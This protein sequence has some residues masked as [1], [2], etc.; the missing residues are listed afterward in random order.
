MRSKLKAVG[1]S[2]HFHKLSS[3]RRVEQARFG[4]H[5]QC[6]TLSETVA[7]SIR[8]SIGLSES[9]LWRAKLKKWPHWPCWWDGK[10]R[11]GRSRK[12]FYKPYPI[13]PS[14]FTTLLF[15]AFCPFLTFHHFVFDCVFCCE[16]NTIRVHLML[17]EW[18]DCCCCFCPPIFHLLYVSPVGFMSE[19]IQFPPS[20]PALPILS[21]PAWVSLSFPSAFV[22]TFEGKYQWWKFVNTNT[23][24]ATAPTFFSSSLKFLWFSSFYI[25]HF[26]DIDSLSASH[27]FKP[28]EICDIFPIEL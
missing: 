7:N 20:L 19:S 23:T 11:A 3:Q 4:R 28:S 6:F 22:S 8:L 2:R 17:F 15:F 1:A 24:S 10:G 5:A 18:Y 16:W 14:N 13:P 21:A 9:A 26:T 12:S 25:L 27:P